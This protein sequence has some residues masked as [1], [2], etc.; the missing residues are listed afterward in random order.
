MAVGGALLLTLILR[1]DD[2]LLSG[3]T[4]SQ[5][6]AL[7]MTLALGFLIVGYSIAWLVWW[8]QRR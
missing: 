3:M 2:A 8:A 1:E 7:G 5:V 4:G 6:L